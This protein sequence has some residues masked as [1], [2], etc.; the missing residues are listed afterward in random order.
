MYHLFE[1][2]VRNI[3]LWAFVAIAA[4]SALVCAAVMLAPIVEWI[5]RRKLEAM[6]VAPLV[7]G[8]ILYGG[9]KGFWRSVQFPLTDMEVAYLTDSGSRVT[10]NAVH[11]AFSASAMMPS[12]AEIYL[13]YRDAES[14]NDADWVTYTNATLATFPNPLD[15]EFPDAISNVW[16][17]YTTW[18]PGA[19]V[20]TNGIVRIGWMLPSDGG[21]NT[22]TMLRTGIK[23]KPHLSY[24]AE[25]EYLES[26]GTQWID[27]GVVLNQSSA[28]ELRG[29]AIANAG[30][31][32]FGA[33]VSNSSRGFNVTRFAAGFFGSQYDT[34]QATRVLRVDS[35]WH[36]FAQRGRYFSIDDVYTYTYLARTFTTPHSGL[37]F[38]QWTGGAPAP[39]GGMAVAYCKIWDANGVLGRD[40]IPVRFTNEQGVSE[41]AMF[42]RA[43]PTVGMNPDGSA[44]TDGL[45]RN[46]GTGAFL[47]GVDKTN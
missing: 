19:T 26:T 6:I 32:F 46:R 36:T 23:Y 14:T 8:I 33:R 2:V 17:C 29:R 41:G 28:V 38:C 44:R 34:M 31:A 20:L 30:F 13:D 24:D 35:D 25:V 10:S 4:M 40:F 1:T 16:Q 12:D 47:Y 5:K 3:S 45:Y 39:L 27:T 7:V 22:V 18:T 37:L 15:F 21:T 9:S 42:D 11:L 43:N